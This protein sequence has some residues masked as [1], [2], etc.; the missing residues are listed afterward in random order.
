MKKSWV[1]IIIIIIIIA[2][3][4][5]LGRHKIKSMLGMSPTPPPA[6]H[7]VM[8]KPTASTMKSPS[9]ELIMTKKGSTGQQYLT[10]AKGMTLYTFANDK[11]GVS[12][13]SGGCLA[14]WPVFS[15]STAPSTLPANL[16]VITRTDG[17]KQYAWKK[18]P[19]Y[20]YAK[21]SKPGDT[22]G[23]G[24]GGVWNLAQP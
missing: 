10:D 16:S 12:A 3:V 1:W 19:L 22:S 21:D 7:M 18:M 4:G 15:A 11:A 23:N 13:C 8:T 9:T 24:I 6:M 17:T 5:Y 20:Y 14:L 2:I